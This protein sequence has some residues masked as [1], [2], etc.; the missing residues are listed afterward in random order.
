MVLQVPSPSVTI[1]A[2]LEQLD[3]AA[4]PL[5]LP[6]QLFHDIKFACG[7]KIYYPNQLHQTRCCP[8]FTAWLYSAYSSTALQACLTE[9][10]SQIASYDMLVLPN[11]SGTCVDT[12][13]KALGSQPL[14]RQ[15][16]STGGASSPQH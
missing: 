16:D 14:F 10:P 8:V 13:E 2:F 9:S 12:L 15:I 7:S 4:C 3:I 5:D 6:D 11:D 1:S